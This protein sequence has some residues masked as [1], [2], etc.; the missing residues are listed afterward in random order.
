[1]TVRL[2]PAP[3]L[4]SPDDRLLWLLLKGER[5]AQAVVRV[6]DFGLELRVTVDTELRWS[7]LVRDGTIAALALEKR[8]AFEER[9]WVAAE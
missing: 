7:Q 8:R 9:G 5:C 2:V 4:P 6:L 3:Q 1:M